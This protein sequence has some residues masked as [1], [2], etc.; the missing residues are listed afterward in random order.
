MMSKAT[1][2]GVSGASGKMGIEIIKLIL[3][4]TI[5]QKMMFLSISHVLKLHLSISIFV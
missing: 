4:S 2:I 1:K 3:I 5:N